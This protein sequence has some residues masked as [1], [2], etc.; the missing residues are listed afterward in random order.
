MSAGDDVSS[1]TFVP[2]ELFTSSPYSSPLSLDMKRLPPGALPER[3]VPGG[4][5]DPVEVAP[6][7]DRGQASL[8]WV[9]GPV[10]AG[11]VLFVI[12]VLYLVIAA[13]R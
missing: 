2:Q 7:G 12:F 5:I 4:P 3:P 11:V 13:R 6:E 10:V 1:L 8:V 9:V